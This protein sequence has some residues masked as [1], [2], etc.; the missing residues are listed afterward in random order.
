[1]AD[2][3]FPA[4]DLDRSKR[5]LSL[6]GSHWSEVYQ[7]RRQVETFLFAWAQEAK[8]TML[9]FE[10]AQLS[11]SRHTVPVLHR[12]QQYRLILRE[13]EMNVT[14]SSL[15]AYGDGA[16]FGNQ[17][18]TGVL[19]TFGVPTVLN[20][21]EFPIPEGLVD[22]PVI[23]NRISAPTVVLLDGVDYI[24]DTDKGL[25]VFRSNPFEDERLSQVI[26]LDANSEE[27]D[28]EIAVW[29]FRSGWDKHQTYNHWGYLA[30]PSLPSTESYKELVNGILDGFLEGGTQENVQQ[31][32]SAVTGVPVVRNALETVE[33]IFTD[34]HGLVIATDKEVYR[35]AEGSTE[36]VTIGDNVEAGEA[37]V[38]TVTFH[39]LNRGTVPSWLSGLALGP[40]L[41]KP[42]YEGGLVF[43][44]EETPVVVELDVNGYTKVSWA[45]GGDADTVAQ[46][47]ADVHTA[48]VDADTRLTDAERASYNH[49]TTLAH[50]L[51]VR[52]SP[53]TQPT[54]A[55]LPA[56]I[57]PLKFL[58]ENLLRTNA[59]IIRV[60][61]RYLDHDRALDMANLRA[62]G[63]LLPPHTAVIVVAELEPQIE[64]VMMGEPGSGDLSFGLAASINPCNIADIAIDNDLT[65]EAELQYLNADCGA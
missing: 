47:W 18:G 64:T 23:T 40:E 13:S 35:F 43:R 42:G 53:T 55:S 36:I 1:M 62:I 21:Y 49:P 50:M 15:L 20:R 38:D 39:E 52:E 8:Q 17:P 46:Y 9:N 57:N 63:R 65:F 5:M 31:V 33:A 32:L 45:L 30:A 56:V 44:N 10:E 37:L 41:L 28:S 25:I 34:A 4:S 60:K 48:G 12:D 11:D 2:F 7:G 59:F 16:V 54:A 51:D 22:I 6:L 27:A 19:Y 3:N 29:L 14:R 58:I 26:D 61:T 24:V